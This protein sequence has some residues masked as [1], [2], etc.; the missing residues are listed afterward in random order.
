MTVVPP[1]VAPAPGGECVRPFSSTPRDS[2]EGTTAMHVT[3]AT[4]VS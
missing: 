2:G 3:F 1:G 4:R